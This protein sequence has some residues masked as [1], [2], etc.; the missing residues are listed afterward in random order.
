MTR[1]FIMLAVFL[2][3]V[4]GCS[5]L[6]PAAP[7]SG[8]KGK[9]VVCILFKD[10]RFKTEVTGKLTAA[11]SKKG[12]QVVT[13]SVHQAKNCN[14][15]DYGAVVY[16]TELWALH[17]P[18]H[19]KRYYSKHDKAANIIFVIT[20]NANVTIKKPFDAVTS[21]SK[22]DRVEPVTEEILARLDKILK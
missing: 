10:T 2:L 3:L 19:T 9:N 16:M 8:E 4:T 18:W 13:G 14:A 17:T 5:M 22:P 6:K 7:I 21:A 1:Q 12:Y 15:R 20:S 11:L